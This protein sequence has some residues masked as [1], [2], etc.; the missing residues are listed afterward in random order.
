LLM[1]FFVI[2]VFGKFWLTMC[3]FVVAKNYLD[4]V[5]LI[6]H[7]ASFLNFSFNCL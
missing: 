6:L 3:L 2:H 5:H 4:I 7:I 1:N